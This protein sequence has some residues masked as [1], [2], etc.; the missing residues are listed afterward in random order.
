MGQAQPAL[1]EPLAR[2]LDRLGLEFLARFLA[3]ALARRPDDDDTRAELGHVLTRL[4]RH[5]EAL[6]VDRDLV[7]RRGDCETARYNLSCS[8]ALVG[9]V[10]EAL[11]ELER[12]VELGY[13]DP[14]QMAADPDL[15]ALRS[16][17]RFQAL[18]E[19]LRR[20]VP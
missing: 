6:A 11:A 4:G 12:A 3:T 20:V 19:R 7:A 14:D 10:E 2:E 9:R 13:D 18:L 15:A 16:H 17:A 5:A 1:P 8:L